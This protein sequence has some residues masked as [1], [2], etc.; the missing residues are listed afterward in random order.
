MPLALLWEIERTF[1]KTIPYSDAK[2]LDHCIRS[3]LL[4]SAA[5]SEPLR[6]VNDLGDAIHSSSF[7]ANIRNHLNASYGKIM[8]EPVLLQVTRSEKNEH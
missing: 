3:M 8:Q 7:G 2:S 4:N 6:I 1:S 5:S